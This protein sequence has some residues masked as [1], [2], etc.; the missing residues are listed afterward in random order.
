MKRSIFFIDTPKDQHTVTN[1]E[2]TACSMTNV[3]EMLSVVEVNSI[4]SLYLAHDI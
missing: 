3:A 4:F 2:K 1:S